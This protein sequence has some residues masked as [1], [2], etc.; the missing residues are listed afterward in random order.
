MR[1]FRSSLLPPLRSAKCGAAS[2]PPATFSPPAGIFS[3][4]HAEMSCFAA[5]KR[6]S[7]LPAAPL[8]SLRGIHAV[9][10][11]SRTEQLTTVDHV[12]MELRRGK[13][14]AVVGKSGSGKTSLLS[15]I[16]LLNTRFGGEYFYAGQNVALLSDP[17]RSAL[18]ARKI[19]FV[20]QN[21]S[22]IR[23]LKV[24]ENVELPLL[25][26]REKADRKLR[27]ERVMNL[28]RE[29]GLEDKESSYPSALSGGE[30][31]RVAIARALITSPEAVLCDEPT[32][33]LDKKTGLRVME[34]L[35][36]AVSRNGSL[37]L[38]VT[39]DADLAAR[40]DGIFHMDGG[41]IS[42]VRHD[43]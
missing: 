31:Q 41:N 32:G 26:A 8:I 2:E 11:L 38:L 10:S 39:H 29:V 43:S 42:C 16:G 22:L 7:V 36:D 6:P 37:L 27:R 5:E 20:F 33:A 23:H 28:L 3:P 4:P 30:Q 35:H 25:Y 18:R 15:I 12:D 24:W 17:R 34:I 21:Y 9:V 19:G 13:S 1:T 40:C 14:Y